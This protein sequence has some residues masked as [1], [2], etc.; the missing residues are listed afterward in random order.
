MKILVNMTMTE[1]KRRFIARMRSRGIVDGE[2]I[3]AEMHATLEHDDGCEED[4]ESDADECLSC[5][6]S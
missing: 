5:W 3:E 6:S 4:P 2:I 1:Y